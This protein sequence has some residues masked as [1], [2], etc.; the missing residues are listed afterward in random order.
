MKIGLHLV[1]EHGLTIKSDRNLALKQFF[2]P[3][4][5]AKKGEKN[6]VL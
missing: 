2:Q 3:L 6:A 5:I 1:Y 4:A